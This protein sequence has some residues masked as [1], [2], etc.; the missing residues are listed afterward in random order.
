[1]KA[2]SILSTLALLLGLSAINASAQSG[3]WR[4]SIDI[5]LNGS[6]AN[7]KEGAGSGTNFN[8]ANLG[9]I[10]AS[11][12]FE[13]KDPYL[14]SWKGG[15]CDVTDGRLYYRVYK[16]GGT[17]GVY[18]T[19]EFSFACN[20]G[21]GCWRSSISGCGG[22]DQEWGNS[23]ALVDLK[24]AALLADGSPG[25]YILQIYWQTDVSGSGCTNTPNV[26]TSPISA[27]FTVSASLPVSLR[28]FD[29]ERSGEQVQLRWAT[30]LEH[31]HSAF[32]VERSA[33]GSNWRRIKTVRAETASING[34][35]YDTTDEQPLRGLNYYRLAQEDFDGETQYFATKM[36]NMG[37]STS[38]S[39]APNPVQ[40]NEMNV[41][42]GANTNGQS[43]LR[44]F[45]AY[46]RL[47]QQQSID[48]EQAQT[49]RISLENLPTG[50]LFLQ[51]D[52]EL[53]LRVVH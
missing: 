13:L 42:I 29:A 4:G 18:Q 33:D 40:G 39:V 34:R 32:Y 24:A 22:T 2:F 10:D 3:I 9:S 28:F 14:F 5:D 43:T 7:Y 25:T 23:S 44:L 53:P 52:Q 21:T 37:R 31:N 48:T 47:L 17:Q 38:L 30:S 12:T 35:T 20:C 41:F 51:I 1:M 50:V 46:G 11:S 6:V 27:T 8:G 19:V 45:D 36:V 15:S 49:L 16:S 26:T